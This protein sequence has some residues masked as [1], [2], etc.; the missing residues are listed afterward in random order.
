MKDA[1]QPIDDA[2]TR[3]AVFPREPEV[4]GLTEPPGRPGEA[5]FQPGPG[6]VWP[7]G[8]SGRL[9]A[10]F[11]IACGL[12]VASNYLSQPLLPLLVSTFQ[13]SS[14]V[15]GLVVTAT[16]V[17]YALG[18]V[19]IVPLGDRLD[20]RRLIVG[21]LSGAIL[22]LL[23]TALARSMSILLAFA[24]LLGFATVV[25]QVLVPFAATLA[26]PL[27]RGRVVGTVMSGLLLG[28][29]LARTVSGLIS[30]IAGWR[31]V[32][33]IA[34]VLTLGVVVVLWRAL[35]TV[36][37]A[38]GRLTPRSYLRLLGSV[39]DLVRAEPILRRRS[40]YGALTFAAFSAFWTTMAFL[41]AAPPY[42]YDQAIIGLFGLLGAAGALTASVAGRLADRGYARVA[43]GVF[44]AAATISYA[45]LYVGAQSLA[46]LVLGI[47]VLDLGV[48]GTHITN[49]SEIYRLNPDARS[50]L[51]TAYMTSYFIGG[52]L[53]SAVSAAAYAAYGWPGVCV[54][55]AAVGLAG[56]AVWI[57]ELAQIGSVR[58][59]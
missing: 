15:A 44:L 13:V 58:R 52:A 38:G 25:A 16:Q 59:S 20:R 36:P 22:A 10:I 41:L 46:A 56:L 24:L 21:V 42:H 27:E 19:L 55:G 2:L 23:G 14:G 28:I 29:L 57:V 34:T 50:R 39:L 11:A 45:L 5:P 8:M 3:A 7:P 49:Q 37:V 53:G 30:Q 31:A 18:L 6:T 35:P 17:G 26:R 4:A 33:A 48:Q 9:V 12:I 43:T 1:N 47:V 32:Y 40:V 51:T 54:L